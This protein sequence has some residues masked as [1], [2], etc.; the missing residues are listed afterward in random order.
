LASLA[1]FVLL[2]VA[3]TWPLA[4]APGTLS[5]NDNGD[6]ILHEWTIAWL[7]HQIV[8]DPLH[9]FDA[10][11][12]YPERYTLAYSDH[13]L[14]PGIFAAPLLWAGGSP[15]L[16][17]NLLLIAGFALTGWAMSLVIHRWTG[18]W[19]A[20]LLSGSL[21]AFYA[22]TLSRR[23]QLQ[24]QHLEF[25][26]LALFALDRLLAK[27]RATHALGLAG[28]FVLQALTS[29]YWLVFSSVAMAAAVLVRPHAWAGREVRRLAPYVA[30]AGGVATVVLLPFLIPYWLV[31]RDQGL[32]RSLADAAQYSAHLTDY[33]ATGGRL[34]YT[35][36]SHRF[37]SA[38]ALFPGL[39]GLGLAGIAIATGVAVRDLRAR[40]A[41]AC[42]VAAVVLS[43]GPSFP[44]YVTLYT[45]FPLMQGIRS[46]VRFGQ[47]FLLAIAMLAGFGLATIQQRARRA[48]LLLS[49]SLTVGA[50]LEALSAPV[51]YAEYSG[52]DPVYDQLRRTG[53]AVFA[54]F[55]FYPSSE[56]AQ[57]VRYMLASTR[58]W[59]PILNGY[60]GFAP[61]S[62]HLN[63]Q[64]LAA[65]PDR[66][67][68]DH[69]RQVGVT[70][71]LVEGHRMDPS[72][73]AGLSAF[74][75]LRLVVTDGEVSVYL[76]AR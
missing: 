49:L 76:L 36:W 30:L 20:G 53:D 59:K 26:P 40:M 31:S 66:A 62:Y 55:P 2:A 34:H 19:L 18:S 29:A 65:F 37:F 51:Q 43:F 52:L 72:R 9:L 57:N 12:F 54:C 22:M 15:V 17:Y 61:L 70:H 5:R 42:G 39:I 3:H 24:D 23:P 46:P 71:V 74:R 27:P 56:R 11:I 60:S 64:A 75:E 13:L 16:A 47:L 10:N 58:F 35:L 1:V 8:R 4:S 32:T 63:A 21:A 67:S 7:A 69:L 28:W 33:L 38:D 68:I 25:L 6:T 48:A 73:L 45:V 44:P 14:V 50:N 41:L